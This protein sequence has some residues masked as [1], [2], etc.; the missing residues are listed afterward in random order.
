MAKASLKHRRHRSASESKTKT[1]GHRKPKSRATAARV[2]APVPTT[3]QPRRAEAPREVP[4]QRGK[5]IVVGPQ[6]AS[7][8][9]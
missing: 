1:A 6:T 3:A 7:A 2:P 9:G 4:A 8:G 5:A